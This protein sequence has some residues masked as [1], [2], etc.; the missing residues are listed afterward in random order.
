MTTVAEQKKNNVRLHKG[1]SRDEYVHKPLK[2]DAGKPVPT[3]LL[4]S[5]QVNL[6]AG[7]FGTPAN[8]V[9]YVKIP[10]DKI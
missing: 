2:D 7:S 10:V 8:G 9:Q 5:I 6:R 4:P 3:L 1:I